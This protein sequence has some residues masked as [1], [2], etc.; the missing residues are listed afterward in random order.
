MPLEPEMLAAHI[1]KHGP[2]LYHVT[3]AR[4]RYAILHWGLR[5]GSE[6]GR[7]V[8]SDFFRTRPGHVH[9]CDARRVAPLVEVAGERLTL[10]VDLRVLDLARFGTDEDVP[11][12]QTRFQ[13]NP[14]FSPALRLSDNWTNSAPRSLVK[15]DV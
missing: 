13:A 1:E 10:Q 6:L 5:P 2:F 9:I 4:R 3:D 11:Y 12:Q 15:L 14:S 8:R 7:Y